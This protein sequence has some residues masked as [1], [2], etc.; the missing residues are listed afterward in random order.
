M[1]TPVVNAGIQPR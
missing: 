1:R